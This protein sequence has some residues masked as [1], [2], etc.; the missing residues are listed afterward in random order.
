MPDE[1]VYTQITGAPSQAIRVLGFC[2]EF[3]QTVPPNGKPISVPEAFFDSCDECINGISS[4]IAAA[5]SAGPE[6]VSSPASSL[7]SSSSLIDVLIGLLLETGFN[8]L[9]EDGNIILLE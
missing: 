3:V 1:K 4:Q 9:L 5:S 6:D 7:F 2:Y 8:L